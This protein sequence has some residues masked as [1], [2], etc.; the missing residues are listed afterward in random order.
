MVMCW[1]EMGL[2]SRNRYGDGIERKKR[3]GDPNGSEKVKVKDMK[4]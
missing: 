2:H 4:D 3:D 1:E